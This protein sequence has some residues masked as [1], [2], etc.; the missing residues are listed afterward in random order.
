[1]NVYDHQFS[2]VAGQHSGD[3]PRE[4]AMPNPA[5][6]SRIDSRC[7][8]DSAGKGGGGTA[9]P[10]PAGCRCVHLT[11]VHP[12]QDT[13]IW[14]KQCRTLA[15][16]GYDVRLVAPDNQDT[17][18][19]EIPLKRVPRV[20]SRWLRVTLTSWRVLCAALREK[21]QLYH[22][23]DPELIPVALV[24]RLLGKR[25]IYD[26]HEDVPQAMLAKH[27]LPSPLRRIVGAAMGWLETG[28]ARLF[29]GVVAATP[30]IA[31]RFPAGKTVVVQNFADVD[32]FS[33]GERRVEG[34]TQAMVVY[35]GW[36]GE[37]RGI[38]EM[39]QAVSLLP[40]SLNAELVLAGSFS[41]PEMEQVVR[42]LP[43]CERTRSVGWL[44][45][46]EVAD[47]LSR[48]RVG[49][50]TI[51]PT[52]AYQR[53]QPVKLFEYMTAGIPFIASD[54]PY[55]REMLAD[56]D[57]GLFCDPLDPAQIAEAIRHLL[58]NPDQAEAMGRRGR[59]A[60]LEKFTWQSQAETLLDLYARV[61][62]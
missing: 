34:N 31:R 62:V 30:W 18:T 4:T 36:L 44:P 12:P 41:P 3:M 10:R 29:H 1:M 7:S 35:A 13:R 51:H 32:E 11:S 37:A 14:R 45:L 38:R 23:H 20:G 6:K 58:E 24:L 33:D 39:M 9:P 55:W 2:S 46:E 40:D 5:G 53:S 50:V 43:G 54:F 60:A 59:Q 8:P 49:L 56:T 61:L 19:A 16:A 27:Y 57:A 26:V 25:V 15:K 47:L 48:A 42:E 52:P 17:D 28:A 22:F 21:G